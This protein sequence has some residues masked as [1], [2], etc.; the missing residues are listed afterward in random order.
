MK[1]G[2]DVGQEDSARMDEEWFKTE[3]RDR[4]AL[5]RFFFTS[6]SSAEG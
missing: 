1:I 4:R 5:E 3:P 2:A 6:M